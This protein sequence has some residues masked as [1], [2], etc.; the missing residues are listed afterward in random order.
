[1]IK[2]KWKDIPCSLIGRI[3]I[4]K[5]AIPPKAVYRFNVITSKLPMTFFTDLEQI[6]LKFI[7]NH[8]RP[9]IAAILGKKNKAGGI[10]FPD[11]RRYYKTTVIKTVWYWH[12]N[13]HE[14]QWSRIESLEINPDTYNELIFNKG[15]KNIQWQKDSLFSKWFWENWTTA[16]KSMKLEH[17]LTLYTKINSKCLKDLNIRH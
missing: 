9:R 3:N 15:G 2:K 1:M 12:K 6:I 7:C 10:T 11:F 17:T 14:N 8:K 16:C 5:M 13:R 4:A